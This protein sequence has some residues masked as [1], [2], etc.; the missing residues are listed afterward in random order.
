MDNYEIKEMIVKKGDSKIFNNWHKHVGVTEHE[1]LDALKWLC[2]D[3]KDGGKN[4]NR[5]TREIMCLPS[6]SIAKLVRAYYSNEDFKGHYAAE[7]FSTEWTDEYGIKHKIVKQ[8][9]IEFSGF[10]M[11]NA[12]DRV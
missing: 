4:K 12:D 1:F 11:I 5:L 7:D 10:P 3:P 9:G 8:K 2:N 6:G